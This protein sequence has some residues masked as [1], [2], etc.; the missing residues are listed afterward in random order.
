MQNGSL[1]LWLRTKEL[2]AI[3]IK[4]KALFSRV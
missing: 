2:E 1:S 3:D 4:E